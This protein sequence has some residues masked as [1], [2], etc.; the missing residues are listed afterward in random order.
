M[1]LARPLGRF[2]GVIAALAAILA[3]AIHVTWAPAV[4]VIG[5]TPATPNAAIS[6]AGP[7]DNLTA[8]DSIHFTVTTSGAVTLNKVHAKICV[9]GFT[10]YSTTSFGYANAGGTRCVFAAN[11]T[12][13]ALTAI[14]A[15]Y[16]LGPVPFASVTTSGDMVFHAGTGTVSWVNSN[17]F[18][19]NGG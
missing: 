17:G 11:I 4:A 16:Q 9:H 13:G 1:T 5:P 7:T 6:V 15:G 8:G 12:S 3:V 18:A 2:C 14:E 10:S 19:G